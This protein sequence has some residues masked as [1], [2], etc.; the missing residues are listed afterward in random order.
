M[1]K[2]LCPYCRKE[3]RFT[4]ENW[5]KTFMIVDNKT[6]KDITSYYSDMSVF[7]ICDNSLCSR[8]GTYVEKELLSKKCDDTIM[9]IVELLNDTV[10]F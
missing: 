8:K 5:S 3:L 6:I 7:F 4:V 10:L 1:E 2:E 9:E